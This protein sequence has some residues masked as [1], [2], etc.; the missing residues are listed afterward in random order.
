LADSQKTLNR[1]RDFD[2]ILCCAWC[3]ET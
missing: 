1:Y 3:H 2:K